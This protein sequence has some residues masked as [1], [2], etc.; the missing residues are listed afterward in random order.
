MYRRRLLICQEHKLKKEF[1]S[2]SLLPHQATFH[3]R[4]EMCFVTFRQKGLALSAS[5]VELVDHWA[6][7]GAPFEVVARG[8]RQ[9]AESALFHAVP[10]EFPLRSL[11]QCRRS[12][13]AQVNAYLKRHPSPAKAPAETVERTSE[14]GKP[15]DIVKSPL[16]FHQQL[17]R[18]L[19]RELK[20]RADTE[21]FTSAL[22]WLREPESI[23]EALAQEDRVTLRMMRTL[24]FSVRLRA[25]KQARH[26]VEA[27][28]L[29]SASAKRSCLRFHRLAWSKVH[30][31]FRLNV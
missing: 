1:P 22:G 6:E 19:L 24:E 31:A 20:S 5:D 29:T 17:H 8:I 7:S 9:A 16:A 18:S 2:M 12:V 26:Q 23:D 14:D 27:M 30:F 25:L 3:E 10:G 11:K 28:A 13:N 15:H 4:V 21:P